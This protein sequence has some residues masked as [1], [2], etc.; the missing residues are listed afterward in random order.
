MSG[1]RVNHPLSTMSRG[2][3]SAGG[4]VGSLRA[5]KDTNFIAGNTFHDP[6]LL[7]LSLQDKN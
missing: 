6:V 7:P 2:N 3:R 4:T 5:Y 1:S